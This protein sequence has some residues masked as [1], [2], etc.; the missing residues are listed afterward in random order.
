MS[1][2]PKV[3]PLLQSLID[4]GLFD[5]LPPT[6]STFFYDQ[7]KDWDLLFPAERSYHERLFGL[8]DRSDPKLVEELFAPLRATE[9]RMGVNDKNW[10]PRRFTLDQVDFLNRSP[11]YAQWRKVIVE[12]FGKLDPLLDEEIAR[13]GRARLVVVAAPEEIAA[14]PSRMWLRLAAHGKR[15]PVGDAPLRFDFASSTPYDTWRI[16]AHGSLP[17]GPGLQVWLSYEALKPYRARLMSE[18][19]HL[20]EAEQIRGPHRLGTR[21]KELKIRAGESDL[22]QDPVLAEFARAVLLTGN[23]T[24]LVNNTFVEWATVEA[25]RRARPSLAFVSFG[26]RNKM[27]PFSSMLIYTDQDTSTPVATQKD[28]LGTY[29]D[30]EVFYQYVWQEFE[31]YAEYRHNT[32]YL[33][34]CDGMDEMLVIAPRDFPLLESHYP[35]KPERVSAACKEWMGL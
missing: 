21:L 25:V 2:S 15:V 9:A 30:L 11:Y 23:G 18:V 27:K 35:V 7:I 33:F 20:V 26:I 29:V 1:T 28:V 8:L 24:L 34:T 10:P 3:S 31:K 17:A 12:I 22:A 32:A 16:A 14:D 13:S 19:R 5:R 6:F 4:K